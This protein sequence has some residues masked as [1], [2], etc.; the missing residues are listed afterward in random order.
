MK[1][2][3]LVVTVLSV[4]ALSLLLATHYPVRSITYLGLILVVGG[5]LISMLAAF[6]GARNA[7]KVAHLTPADFAPKPLPDS[8]SF[9]SI[10]GIG[11]QLPNKIDELDRHVKAVHEELLDFKQQVE[12]SH[13]FTDARISTLLG[14][15]RHH[16]EVVLPASLASSSDLV[17][18][19]SGFAIIGSILLADPT[20]CHEVLSG[21]AG[22]LQ[23]FIERLMQAVA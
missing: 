5:A 11:G 16:Q 17:I 6:S 2:L 14:V 12:R 23:F 4:I 13:A 8:S 3:Y 10:Y 7:L 9:G 20:F 18:A 22:S 19:S 1:Y 15:I 21:V